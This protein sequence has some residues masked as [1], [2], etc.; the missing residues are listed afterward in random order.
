MNLQANN[1]KQFFLIGILNL[2]IVAIL[3]SIMR[4]KIGF[5]FP[6][7]SQKFL[8]H[9]HSHFAFYGWVSHIL[10]SAIS[11]ILYIKNKELN[12][13]RLNILILT[14]LV[15]SYLMLFSFSLSGY[16]ALSII[17]STL[18][19]LISYFYAFIANKELDK[20]TQIL[21]IKFNSN[22]NFVQAENQ[23]NNFLVIRNFFKAALLFLVLSSLGTFALAYM[24]A[25]KMVVQELYLSSVYYYLHFQYNGWFLFGLIGLIIYLLDY[26]IT[27]LKINP[28]IFHLLFYACIPAYLLS[29]L[30]ANLPVTLNILA[31]ISSLMQLLALIIFLK[32]IWQNRESIKS[33]LSKISIYLLILVAFSSIVKFI[34]QALSNI[35]LISKLAYEFR[36]I[37]ISYLHLVLLCI[38][39]LGLLTVLIELRWIKFNKGACVGMIVFTIGIFINE[40]LLTSQGVLGFFYEVLPY[41]NQMLFFNSLIII[42]GIALV[43]LNNQKKS[44]NHF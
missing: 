23:Q 3:G 14:N 38:I 26:K 1:T 5:E 6:Y 21:K 30:W 8:Q 17:L 32:I 24:N 40:L 31:I 39:T 44:P 9:S 10:M 12:I 27:E 25:M 33:K 41:S 13:R 34:L 16:S 15:L 37:V 11:H 36:P 43:L 2:L 4:Y 7:L 22:Q 35:P 19:I 18:S 42:I 28:L 29:L 20:V